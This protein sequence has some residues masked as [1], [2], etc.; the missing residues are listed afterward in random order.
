MDAIQQ[1]CMD[2]PPERLI[3]P[4]LAEKI[5]RLP[6]P[7]Q[8]LADPQTGNLHGKIPNDDLFQHIHW[9]VGDP[10]IDLDGVFTLDEV[11]ALLKYAKSFGENK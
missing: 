3:L 4:T 9:T 5:S 8:K 7:F 10:L 1:W 6:E 2:N 11:A